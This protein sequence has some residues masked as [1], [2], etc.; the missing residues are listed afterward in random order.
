MVLIALVLAVC[1]LYAPQIAKLVPAVDPFLSAYVTWVDQMRL[2]LDGQ[3]KS[4]LS[5]LDTM[6]SQSAN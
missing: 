6:A 2:S 1:Y 3:L 5:W 4:L